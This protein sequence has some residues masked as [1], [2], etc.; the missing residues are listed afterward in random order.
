MSLTNKIETLKA[1][2]DEIGDGYRIFFDGSIKT[3]TITDSLEQ[4][5]YALAKP[6]AGAAHGL[7]HLFDGLEYLKTDGMRESIELR[8]MIISEVSVSDRI[9]EVKSFE[10]GS[11]PSLL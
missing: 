10:S 1:R 11:L 5:W 6:V 2:Q 3:A 4:G 7:A 9:P 8:D